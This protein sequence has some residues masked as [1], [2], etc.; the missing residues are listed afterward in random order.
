[1]VCRAPVG[2]IS[3]S[4]GR[5]PKHISGESSVLE[6]GLIPYD[7]LPNS[8]VTQFCSTLLTH[9]EMTRTLNATQPPFIYVIILLPQKMQ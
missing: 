2:L 3:V 7:I 8:L 5:K 6:D 4:D 9:L 1:M